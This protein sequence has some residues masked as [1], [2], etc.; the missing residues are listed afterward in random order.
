MTAEARTDGEVGDRAALLATLVAASVILGLACVIT[1]LGGWDE[2]SYLTRG[3]ALLTTKPLADFAPLYSFFYWVVDLVVRDPVGLYFTGFFLVELLLV[4]ACY[5]ALRGLGLSPALAGLAALC[6]INIAGRFQPRP[7]HLV[8]VIVLGALCIARRRPSAAQGCVLLGLAATIAAYMRPEFGL[9]AL[10]IGA[11]TVA[12]LART[13]WRQRGFA[14]SL[15]ELAGAALWIGAAAALVAMFG[16]PFGQRSVTAFGSH[17][18]LHYLA[19]TGSGVERWMNW[20]TIYRDVFHDAPSVFQALETNPVLFLRHVL[21]NIGEFPAR[22]AALLLGYGVD[23]VPRS[24]TMILLGGAVGGVLLVVSA[25]GLLRGVVF[26][27]RLSRPLL[28]CLA[29]FILPGL[30]SVAVIY[31]HFHY[32]LPLCVFCLMFGLAT[33]RPRLEG[34]APKPVFAVLATYLLLYTM[35]IAW[36][37][38]RVLMGDAEFTANALPRRTLVAAIG[39]L[40]VTAPVQLLEDVGDVAAYLPPNFHWVSG[41]YKSGA[42]DDYAREHAVNM[43][44]LDPLLLGDQRFLADPE[45]L[46]LLADPEQAGWRVI[47]V[48]RTDFRLLVRP[49]LLPGGSETGRTGS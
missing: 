47:V 43:I 38:G 27:P 45:W 10:L 39:G 22:F 15:P 34:P 23:F 5:A 44:V 19:W 16:S 35:A 32:M 30:I 17:F 3:E 20:E 48:P 37:A 13:I 49:S 40:G 6:L 26:R 41:E 36:D 14:G 33:L 18:A 11:L 12:L 31:P 2:T 1:D 28:A 25:V 8:V 7:G 29:A 21:A 9:T 4:A 42:F 24:G 46:G